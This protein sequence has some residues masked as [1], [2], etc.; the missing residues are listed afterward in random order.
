MIKNALNKIVNSFGL[1][2]S[3][4]PEKAITSDCPIKLESISP[5]DVDSISDIS[6]SI[7]G[8]IEAASGKLLYSLCYVQAEQGDVVEVGSWQGRSTSFLGR[9]VE[10]SGNGSLYAVDH[11]K[12]NV[13]KEQFYVVGKDDLSDLEE[14]FLANMEHLNLSHVVNLLNM[15][16]TDAAK[17]LS[18]T[19]IRFLF[20]DGDHTSRGVK[21]DLELFAPLLVEGAIV[22]F[23]DFSPNF[24]GVVERVD[25]FI[26]EKKPQRVMSYK[27]Q[28]AIKL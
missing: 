13:G 1:K 19:S 25:S 11:F 17:V 27:N 8:M 4:I 21:R 9:A 7:P 28:I 12:G 22:V 14:S 5:Y 24:P 23:D 16:N 26:A 20:I 2:I 15:P 10:A 3:R 18:G 6:L